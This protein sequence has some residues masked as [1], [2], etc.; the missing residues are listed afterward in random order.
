MIWIIDL[1]RQSLDR[2]IPGVRAGH[3]KALFAGAGWHVFEAKYGTRLEAAM[4]GP[5][6]AALRQRIDEM[7][8]EEYQVLIRIKD[9][10][11]LRRRLTDVADPGYRRA[12]SASVADTSDDELNDL[13]ANL[14]GHDLPRLL[15]V[16]NQADAVT[17]APIGDLRLHRQGLRSADRRRS[18]QP[19]AAAQPGANGHVCASPGAS[20]P[21]SSGPRFDPPFRPPGSGAATR[22]CGC[23]DEVAPRGRCST[24]P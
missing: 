6:G 10:A 15:D 5:P 22:R 11:E 4:I 19:L 8:N 7:S 13:I 23:I 2:V 16:L 24:P 17:D 20:R 9:G 12:D 1:N 14:G 21:T 3:L 18:A